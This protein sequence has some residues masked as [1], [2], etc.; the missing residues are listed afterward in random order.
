MSAIPVRFHHLTVASVASQL[1]SSTL[2]PGSNTTPLTWK[3]LKV[4]RDWKVHIQRL[5]IDFINFNAIIMLCHD[6]S[7][8]SIQTRQICC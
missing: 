8:I 7:C 1:E 6:S 3:L 2:C 4:L 5:Q